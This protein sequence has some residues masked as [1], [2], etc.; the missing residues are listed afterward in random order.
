MSKGGQRDQFSEVIKEINSAY[1]MNTMTIV[2]STI[3]E[4]YQESKS[5]KAL[6]ERHL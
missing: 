6:Q 2:N 5:K 3:F 4:S 1:V